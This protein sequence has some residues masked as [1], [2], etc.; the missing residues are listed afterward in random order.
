MQWLKSVLRIMY[1]H[2]ILCFGLLL[3]TRVGFNISSFS[4]WYI[5]SV[6]TLSINSHVTK[7]IQLNDDVWFSKNSS[8]ILRTC[9][10]FHQNIYSRFF[11]RKMTFR[12]IIIF[13]FYFE[14]WWINLITWNRLD[15]NYLLTYAMNWTDLYQ[16]S[17]V[18]LT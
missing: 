18:K 8:T 10:V 2:L 11:T 3:I 16:Q 6:C 14:F 13:C 12:F 1:Q 9:K 4:Y 15:K 7:R 17:L 5:M